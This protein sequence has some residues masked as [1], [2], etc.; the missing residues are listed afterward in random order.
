[1]MKLMH[2]ML[3]SCKQATFYIS[4]KNYKNL[5]VI[6]KMQ[7]KLHLLMC[8]NCRAFKEQNELIDKGVDTY[9]DPQLL[10][11]E[12]LSDQKKSQLKLTVNQSIN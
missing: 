9:N 11:E 8:A 10:A 12:K 2:I 6:R 1:M 5:T 3:L 7:L 4:I